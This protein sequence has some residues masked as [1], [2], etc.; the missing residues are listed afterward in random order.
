MTDL[1]LAQINW[2][3][4]G[5]VVAICVVL[6]TVLALLIFLVS[7]ICAVKEDEK[8]KAIAE[9]LAGANCG[10]CGFAGCADFA[11]ALSEG[12]AEIGRCGPTSNENKKEIAEILGIPFAS[13]EETI[14]VVHCAGGDKSKDKFVYY[15]NEGCI[16]QSACMG[17]KKVCKEGCLGGGTCENN[18]PYHAITLKD[19]VAVVSREAC[20]SCGLCVKNCPK[21][22]IGLIPK[23]AVVYVACSSSCKGKEAMDICKV[24]CIGCGLCAKVCPTGAITMNNNFPVI[25][26]SKC[27]GC[28]TCVLKCPRNCIK[29]L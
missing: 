8:A 21:S 15:G 27:T 12:R 7:K 18:C 23:S 4:F 20:E 9:K 19:G 22:I 11:K 10:G 14:A 28:K 16:A 24:S 2:K 26:Y 5:I 6:S 13:G 29:E 1:L 25:D 3:T 17:G